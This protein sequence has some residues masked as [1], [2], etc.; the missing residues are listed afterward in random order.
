MMY[1]IEESETKL[2]L[3]QIE[4]RD[5]ELAGPFSRPD[6]RWQQLRRGEPSPSLLQGEA[7]LFVAGQYQPGPFS[8]PLRV[9]IQ[10]EIAAL[11]AEQR[12]ALRQMIAQLLDSQRGG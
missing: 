1:R 11:D 8:R 12:Q 9:F 4:R 2:T 3:S 7:S 5:N 6:V 10:R